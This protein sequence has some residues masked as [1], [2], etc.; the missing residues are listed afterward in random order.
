[1]REAVWQLVKKEIP[2]VKF[3]TVER[4][5]RWLQNTV[6]VHKP[7]EY[8]GRYEKQADYIDAFAIRKNE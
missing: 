7:K 8:D 1:M 4:C 6:G 3:S 5:C 2:Y